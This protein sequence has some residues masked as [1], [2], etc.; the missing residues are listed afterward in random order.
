M[1]KSVLS[2]HPSRNFAISPATLPRFSVPESACVCACSVE[3]NQYLNNATQRPAGIVHIEL[4]YFLLAFFVSILC[5]RQALKSTCIISRAR[6]AQQQLV[7]NREYFVDVCAVGV[8][9]N[10]GGVW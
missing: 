8:E 5:T 4:V 9:R 1:Y 3:P 2:L 6:R 10:G 7:P